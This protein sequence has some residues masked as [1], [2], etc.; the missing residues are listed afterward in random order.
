[1]QRLGEI[2]SKGIHVR[3][4]TPETL[5][6]QDVRAASGAPCR[7]GRSR[8]QPVQKSAGKAPVSFGAFLVVRAGENIFCCILATAAQAAQTP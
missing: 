8:R 3:Q 6:R 7:R 4:S 1:L 2:I 5:R